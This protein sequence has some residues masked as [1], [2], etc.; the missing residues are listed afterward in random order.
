MPTGRQV[1]STAPATIAIRMPKRSDAEA[2]AHIHQAAW[3][4][5]YLG[6]LP[7]PTLDAMIAGRGPAQWLKILS[8]PR[9]LNIIELGGSIAGY[10]SYGPARNRWGKASCEIY[11]IYLAPEYQG[12][13]LGRRLFTTT[14][15]AATAAHG[16]GL[17][18]WALSENERAGQF[19]LAMGGVKQ[20][21][22]TDNLGNKQFEKIAYLWR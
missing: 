21:T 13:G 5:A 6:I 8:R 4:D 10:A 17:V 15:A 9:G 7:G 3:R 16:R 18:I 14:R 12:V 19:Y 11:E 2:I 20:G 22:A 1:M